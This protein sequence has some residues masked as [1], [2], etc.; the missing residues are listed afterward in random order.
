MAARGVPQPVA[1]EEASRLPSDIKPLNV[2][3]TSDGPFKLLDFGIAKLVDPY[4][5]R[6]E[7]NEQRRTLLSMADS[8][9]FKSPGIGAHDSTTVSVRL[10]YLPQK[11]LVQTLQVVGALGNNG[12]DES[13]G[14]V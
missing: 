6:S 1:M 4:Q 12:Q 10:L 8:M 7:G 9:Y 13:T 11:V 5:M 3:V 14:S 2:L